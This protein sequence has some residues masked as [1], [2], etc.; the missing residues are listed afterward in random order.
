MGR[1][2]LDALDEV[3]QACFIMDPR[4]GRNIWANK[5]GLMVLD[6][7]LE[8]HQDSRPLDHLEGEH[9][10]RAEGVLKELALAVQDGGEARDLHGPLIEGDRLTGL[11]RKFVTTFS[12]IRVKNFPARLMARFDEPTLEG[13]PS[14]PAPK[15]P[16][17]GVWLCLGQCQAITKHVDLAR[18]NSLSPDLSPDLANL[19]K[20]SFNEGV[21]LALSQLTGPDSVDQESTGLTIAT[22]RLR[23]LEMLRQSPIFSSLFERDGGELVM[24]TP[25]ASTFYEE[26]LGDVRAPGRT[27]ITL[28][29]V[30]GVGFFGVK[31]PSEPAFDGPKEALE[32]MDK[33][34]YIDKLPNF[35]FQQQQLTSKRKKRW[36]EFECWP[37]KDPVTGRESVLVSQTNITQLKGLEV[38]LKAAQKE[39][40]L[41]N[42]QLKEELDLQREKQDGAGLNLMGPLDETLAMLARVAGGE[43]QPSRR[44][45]EQLM[46]T[47]ASARDVRAPTNLKASLMDNSRFSRDVG[48][49][50]MTMLDLGKGGETRKGSSGSTRDS[51]RSSKPDGSPRT[52]PPQI[53]I[54]KRRRGLNQKIRTSLPATVSELPGSPRSSKRGSGRSWDSLSSS[55]ASTHSNIFKKMAGNIRKAF[56]RSKE[57]GMAQETGDSNETIRTPTWVEQKSERRQRRSSSDNISHFISKA[58]RMY[59]QPSQMPPQLQRDLET[60]SSWQFDAFSLFESS[61]G[62]PLSTLG[63]YL[64][65]ESGLV[66]RFSIKEKTLMTFLLKVEDGYPENMYHNRTHAAD[67]LQSM[68]MLM[69]NALGGCI[70]DL[71]LLAGIIAAVCH[72]YKHVGVNNDFLVRSGHDLAVLYNGNSPMENHHAS[73]TLFLLKQQQYDFLAEADAVDRRQFN[74]LFISLILSTDMSSHFNIVGKF[75]NMF[76][77]EA[78]IE[79]IQ[80]ASANSS[81]SFSAEW[82]NESPVTGDHISLALQMTIKMADLGHVLAEPEV[83][84]KWVHSLEEEYFRQGDKEKVVFGPS[85]ASP[86]MD[87]ASPGITAS[88]CGFFE[89]VVVPLYETFANVFTG[90][91]PALRQVHINY[92][93]WQAKEKEG[94]EMQKAL[95]NASKECAALR[96]GGGTA[97]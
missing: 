80:K 74:K 11:G 71:E 41:Q 96:A 19:P 87:R 14:Q 62:H 6:R 34:L 85:S 73:S 38:S 86:L 22:E 72:D 61:K 40:T 20:G 79:S 54:S 17:S 65:K 44:E 76:T 30:F 67:V 3:P 75:N 31:N 48:M 42:T 26:R 39:L 50:L 10:V 92:G 49:S 4:R 21:S 55:P 90:A 32:A 52:S 58:C 77:N 69:V 63:F 15:S 84:L 28:E 57:L 1:G 8:E 23:A 46:K 95:K 18:M 94:Q 97:C 47:L 29:Q 37:A 64:I 24:A 93:M 33:A 9:L 91:A 25:R 89:I 83:H 2:D 51:S 27:C 70:G 35:K 45:I 59:H 36:V 13:C 43:E 82:D 12:R 88:Q 53:S 56:L 81:R 66:Q 60:S 78:V 68:Y 5:G 7:T 16:S